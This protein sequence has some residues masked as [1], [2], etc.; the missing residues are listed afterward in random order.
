MTKEEQLQADNNKLTV[1][2][3]QLKKKNAE[4]VLKNESLEDE[5]EELEGEVSDLKNHSEYE[6]ALELFADPANW[7]GNVWSPYQKWIEAD[8]PDTIA[9]QALKE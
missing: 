5:V 8:M 6:E 4:L 7:K 2:N 9:A 1:E 3:E